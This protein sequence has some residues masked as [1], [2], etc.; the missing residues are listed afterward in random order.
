MLKNH[1]TSDSDTNS[2][3]KWLPLMLTDAGFGESDRVEKRHIE[4]IQSSLG[5]IARTNFFNGLPDQAYKQL[6]TY[7]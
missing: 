3:N 6:K 5:I 4:S 1:M 7:A 2:A